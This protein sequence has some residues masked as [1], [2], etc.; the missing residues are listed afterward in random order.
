MNVI[1]LFVTS[2]ALAVLWSAI[3]A[4]PV[5]WLWDAVIPSI[6]GLQEITWGQAWCLSL[7]CNFLFKS[8]TS[9]K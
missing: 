1:A 4:L 5:M 6:F 2:V 3:L 9:S 7:L 8:H